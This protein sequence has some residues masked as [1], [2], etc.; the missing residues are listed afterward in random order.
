[1]ALKILLPPPTN[2]MLTELDYK[3]LADSQQEPLA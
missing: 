1:M 3:L 2:L